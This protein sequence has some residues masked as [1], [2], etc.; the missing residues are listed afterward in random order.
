[1]PSCSRLEVAQLRAQPIDAAVESA[2]L[3]VEG[4]DE[5]PEEALAFVG[6]LRAGGP[7]AL[8]EDSERFAHRVQCVVC[9]P[10]FAG[11]ELVAFRRG[12]VELRVVANGGGD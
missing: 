2:D 9:V 11:V 6:E 4:V 1:M 8:C 3:G 10:D 12:A 5:A 7:D